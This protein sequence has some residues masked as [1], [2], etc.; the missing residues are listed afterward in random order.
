[1]TRSVDQTLEKP[2][3]TATARRT[4]ARRQSR[5]GNNGGGRKRGVT[6]IE[7][8]ERDCA[9]IKRRLAG[10]EW[11]VIAK[12]F[13]ISQ[14]QARA[15]FAAWRDSGKPPPDMPE[16]PTAY[17]HE[18]LGRMEGLLDAAAEIVND[19]RVPRETRLAAIRV[20]ARLIADG[21]VMR[22]ATGLLP[23][24]SE[25]NI[26]RDAREAVDVI[27]AC[28]KRYEVPEAAMREIAQALRMLGRRST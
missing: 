20:R 27:S 13:G 19:S 8:A 14:S 12:E 6:A 9:L 22:S 5:V 16:D 10:V 2:A 17:L 26:A 15:I 4:R 3:G 1:M 25:V 24:P 11:P 28:F 23:T 18:A 7:K 21:F